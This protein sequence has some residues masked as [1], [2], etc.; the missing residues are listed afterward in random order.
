MKLAFIKQPGGV[1]VP[2]SDREVDRMNRFPTGG[3]IE[4]EFKITRNPAFHRKVFSFFNFCY[5]H[6]C[7]QGT[8]YELMDDTAQFDVF[9]KNLT[10]LA[11]YYDEFITIK[12]TVRVE[13]KSLAYG[14]ME[15]P[16]FERC[17]SALINAAI[18]HVFANTKD[19]NTLNT[20]YGFF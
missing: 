12:G 10:V 11:G 4:A 15:Q 9:R 1:L 14:N 18:K 8:N 7:G 6:W 3:L 17:Y 19:Q 16:E 20:L 13:A 5:E 2:A